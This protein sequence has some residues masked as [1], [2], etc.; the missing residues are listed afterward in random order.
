MKLR[1]VVLLR[2]RFQEIQDRNSGEGSE[3]N[4]VEFFCA[5]NQKSI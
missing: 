3:K 1:N 2:V 5:K 4:K